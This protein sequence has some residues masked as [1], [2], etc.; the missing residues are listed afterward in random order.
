[1]YA[2]TVRPTDQTDAKGR[3]RPGP[4]NMEWAQVPT[5]TPASG[6]VRVAVKAVGMNRADLLQRQGLYPPPPGVSET[7]GLEV[8]GTIDALG[9]D[10]D[11]WQMGDEVVALLAGGGYAEQVIVPAGQLLHMPDGVEPAVASTL[12]EV[13]ATVIS[14]MDHVHLHEGETIL[15]H[16]GAGGIG[17]FAIQY[18]KARGCRVIVTAGTQEKRDFCR[19][20]GADVAIDYHEDWVAAVK[21]ATDG[22]GV[23]VILDIMGAKYLDANVDLSLIHI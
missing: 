22:A 17:Q 14:N 21:E 12:V 13:A 7:M 1:M 5:P 20:L 15:V 16:G 3:H 9:D 8:C 10:V 4:E 23:D 18:A 2:I 11:G 6:E 19:E